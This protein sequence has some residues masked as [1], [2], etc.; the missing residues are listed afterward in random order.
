MRLPS[1]FGIQCHAQIFSCVPMWNDVM[2][3]IDCLVL[4]TLIGKVDVY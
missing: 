4:N 1:E 3:D 2:V